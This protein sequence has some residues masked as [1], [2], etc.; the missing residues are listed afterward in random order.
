[1]L[2]L[3]FMKKLN[4]LKIFILL[5]VFPAWVFAQVKEITLEPVEIK[6]TLDKVPPAVKAAVV[7]DFGEEHQPVVWANSHSQFSTVGWEQNVNPNN[8]D[9][10]Y[11]TI[12]TYKPNG[13]YLEAVYTPEGKL[14]RSREEIKNFVPPQPI[15]A[16]LQK[17]DYKDWT[18]SKNV[19]L[20]KAVEGKATKEHYAFKLEKGKDKK[21]VYFDK[22]GNMLMNKP[23]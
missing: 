2:N 6:V 8:M 22:D 9:I 3:F 4:F 14:T 17:S 1:M 15:L 13:S 10:N 12:H 7:R 21:T 5:A 11:Y 18:I 16:S 23:K 20:I 19:L